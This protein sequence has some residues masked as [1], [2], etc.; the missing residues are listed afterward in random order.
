VRYAQGLYFRLKDEVFKGRRP[1]DSE[2]LESFMKKEF[3]ETTRMSEKEYPRV[4]AKIN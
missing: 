1:Y 3:G 2:P 4:L